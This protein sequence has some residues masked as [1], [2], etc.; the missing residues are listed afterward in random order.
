MPRIFTFLVVAVSCSV[1]AAIL[2]AQ[3]PAKRESED[4]ARTP[5]A[6]TG[7]TL[8][9]VRKA[10]TP[11]PPMERA[12]A[13]LDGEPP[14]PPPRPPR[15]VDAEVFAMTD[16]QGNVRAELGA[17]DTGAKMQM[18][19]AKGKL[20]LVMTEASG[21]STVTLV[22]E[23][24]R[25]GLELRLTPGGNATVAIGP[26]DAK[27]A[28]PLALQVQSGG[29]AAVSLRNAAGEE[30]LRLSSHRSEGGVVEV[31]AGGSGGRLKSDAV[32]LWTPQGGPHASL[33]LPNGNRAQLN[34]SRGGGTKAELELG[35][36][37]E[38]SWL[39]LN[40]KGYGRAGLRTSD[41]GTSLELKPNGGE[42]GLSGGTR[43]QDGKTVTHLYLSD[44]DGLQKVQ[45]G[46]RSGQPS[47]RLWGQEQ[48]K[49][50]LFSAP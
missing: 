39:T 32:S 10:Y 22:G 27:S 49:P 12:R 33:G 2:L 23:D 15:I 29:D 8:D 14:P 9:D 48:G 16:R 44:I 25:A 1:T 18:F 24:G 38:A 41:D 17:C 20:R 30:T 37:G 28:P 35:C 34:M 3:G 46:V 36:A 5:P 6:P 31:H 43:F 21:A 4:N 42:G 7:R 45:V 19:D 11:P 40:T 26:H 50:A 13:R 47:L